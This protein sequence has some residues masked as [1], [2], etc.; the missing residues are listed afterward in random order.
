MPYLKNAAFS[1][2]EVLVALFLGSLLTSLALHQFFSVKK[3]FQYLSHTLHCNLNESLIVDLLRDT[4]FHAGFTPYGSIQQL[5][6]LHTEDTRRITAIE[7]LSSP[8][9]GFIARRMGSNY[10]PLIHI[11]T[12]TIAIPEFLHIQQNQPLIVCNWCC[13]QLLTVKKTYRKNDILY[14][15]LQQTLHS[16][17][18]ANSFVGQWLEERYELKQNPHNNTYGL[19]Y[20]QHHHNELLEDNWTSLSM[21]RSASRNTGISVLLKDKQQKE[22]FILSEAPNVQVL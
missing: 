22:V 4:V 15:E 1:L 13:Y 16:V 9:H 18:H 19:Y 6:P 5:Q 10:V 3:Q 2:S 12:N 8:L 11:H 21:Q 17:F 14:V 7:P 20:Y